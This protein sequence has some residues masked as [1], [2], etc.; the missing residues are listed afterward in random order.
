MHPQ[1]NCWWHLAVS[2]ERMK[3]K[4]QVM[5]WILNS[6]RLIMKRLIHGLSSIVYMQM[7]SP[8]LCQH[9]TPMYWCYC[10][11]IFRQNDT[12][13][14]VDEDW[15]SKKGEVYPSTWNPWEASSYTNITHPVSC[16]N[17]LWHCFTLCWTQQENSM[18][19]IPDWQ[20]PFKR[21]WH[22]G[23]TIAL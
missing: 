17:R 16:S 6:Y 23:P 10:W 9:G 11:H 13:Q 1:I 7:P 2:R 15:H 19:G 18:E 4:H 22:R 8:L 20:S 5:D 21:P 12:Y 3:F 14:V